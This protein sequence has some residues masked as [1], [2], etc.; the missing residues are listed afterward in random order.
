MGN[1]NSPMI[2]KPDYVV[3]QKIEE[4]NN[5]QLPKKEK[6]LH[7]KKNIDKSIADKEKNMVH[8]LNKTKSKNKVVQVSQKS[9]N[10]EWENYEITQYVATGNRTSSGRYPQ[11]GRTVASNFLPQ[12]TVIY[13][14][15]L[16]E[17]VVEDT[18][19]SWALRRNVIDVYI[20]GSRQNALN[21][22]RQER[23]VKIIKMGDES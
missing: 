10:S 6:K 15:G 19:S 9:T 1:I 17:R 22:G 21:F 14:E 18:G 12:D 4:L 3:F 20:D 23:R 7:I 13:I 5:A 8:N 16:G 2:K 11:G